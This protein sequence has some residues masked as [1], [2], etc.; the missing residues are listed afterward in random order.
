MSCEINVFNCILFVEPKAEPIELS[1]MTEAVVFTTTVARSTQSGTELNTEPP[2]KN[3]QTTTTSQG[4]IVYLLTQ[5][6][7]IPYTTNCVY[8][9]QPTGSSNTI[10]RWAHSF[11]TSRQHWIKRYSCNHHR[12]RDWYPTDTDTGCG[13]WV[14]CALSAEV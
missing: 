13:Y 11:H 12:C 5:Y 4:E 14:G 9:N 3:H 8:D 7:P 6:T 2:S 10:N 1:T